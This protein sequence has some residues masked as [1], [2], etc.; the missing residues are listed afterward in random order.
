MPLLRQKSVFAFK[1]EAT[2]GTQ[3]S[4]SGTDGAFNVWDA[5]IEPEISMAERD[6]QGSFSNLVQVPEQRKAKATF[7]TEI[8]GDGAAGVPGWAST[9][10]PAC[11]LVNSAGVFSLKAEAPGSNVKTLTMAHYQDG[12]RSIMY[13]A[14]GSAKFVLEAGKI[15]YIDWTFQGLW[16]G[17]SD[18]SILTPTYPTVKPFRV[19]SLPAFNIGSWAPC[20]SKFELDLG[21]IIA[22][23]P[24]AGGATGFTHPIIT[25]RKIRGSIDPEAALVASADPYGD[26]LAMT[27]SDFDLDLA[28]ST[29]KFQ[30]D[31]PKFQVIGISGGE[32]SGI[33]VD[34]I[35][36]ALNRSSANN[37]ELTITFT[38]P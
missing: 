25:G 2:A 4:L 26:W 7:R 18:V 9:L 30:F 5:K 6:A 24:C 31:A 16:G 29:D 35:Q 22:D 12:R 13:G 23:R 20:F 21:N 1:T 28:S 27:E 17:V 8:H 11:G 3:E 14:V 38:S 37:D 15:A 36:F 32:R 10:F 34:T 33:L 19:A